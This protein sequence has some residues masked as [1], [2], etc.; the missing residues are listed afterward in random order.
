MLK[1]LMITTT[2]AS[3]LAVTPTVVADTG[4]SKADRQSPENMNAEAGVLRT[5]EDFDELD[6]NKDGLLDEDELNTWGS[7]AAGG[8]DQKN[9][10]LDKYDHNNDHRV[11]LKELQ[12][13]PVGQGSDSPM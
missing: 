4:G 1:Q 6:T 5:A 13:G 7:T 10:L 2:I 3:A 8:E 9:V 11:S 12:D